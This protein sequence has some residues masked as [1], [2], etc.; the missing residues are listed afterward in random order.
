MAESTNAPPPAISGKIMKVADWP[1]RDRAA[2][3]S[4]STSSACILD[5]PV[6]SD[7]SADTKELYARNYGGFLMWLKETGTLDVT[8]PPI[9]R[10]TKGSVAAFMKARCMH[11]N[12]Y[13]TLEN[14]AFSLRHVMR[15]L[16]PDVDWS[17]L[18]PLVQ[19]MKQAQTA[20]PIE[21]LPTILELFELGIAVMEKADDPSAG[22][23]RD[24]AFLYRTGLS[25]ALL[26]A[27]PSMRRK[28]LGQIEIGQHLKKEAGGYRLSF[29]D[30]DMKQGNP[31]NAYVPPF[32]TP[33]IDR[34]IAEYRQAI[35]NGKY[36]PG[37]ALWL[38]HMGGP[39]GARPLAICVAEA[40]KVA[41]GKRVSV[42]K[43]RHCAA[44]SIAKEDP[45][46]VLNVPI[47]LGHSS[48]K[49]SEKFYIFADRYLAYVMHDR[50]MTKLEG[51]IKIAEPEED[52][53][54]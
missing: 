9:T 37:P 45:V 54:T 41:F 6:G 30:E 25:I 12:S 8:A 28:N 15:V 27:R 22:T 48:F 24:R 53:S 43:F 38:S 11:G 4:I 5:V 44:T 2:W 33:Y 49:V 19:L 7:W 52:K 26:A 32:L 36:Q 13:R 40:T 46:N 47:I 50:A 51:L 39:I 17:W 14:Y 23:V 3:L 10:V 34:Y 18:L 31:F 20:K 16:A 21:G 35:V 29:E 1:E 42:H